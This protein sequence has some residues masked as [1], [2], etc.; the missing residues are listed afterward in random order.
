[1]FGCIRRLGCLVI[2]AIGAG[3]WYWYTRLREPEPPRATTVSSRAKSGWEPLSASNAESGRRSV[4]DLSRSSGPVFANLSA[5]E[6]ASYIFLSAARQL[7]PSAQNAAASVQGDELVVRATVAL[8]EFGGTKVLGPFAEFLGE[9]DTVQLG[10]RITVKQAGLAQFEVRR[11]K[12]GSLSV[13]GPL[14]PR[15][16]NQFRRGDRAP[17]ISDNG[18]PMPIPE[19]ISDVRISNGRVTL[20]KNAQ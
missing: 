5:G 3:G 20:Y 16:L 11:I 7:P 6:A 14:I 4:E 1:M 12:I 18:L 9:R 13:P 15:L 2:L 19:Y 10:G 17:G 8:K